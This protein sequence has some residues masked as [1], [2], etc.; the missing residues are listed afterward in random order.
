[1]SARYGLQLPDFGWIAGSDPATTLAR[2]RDVAH[3]AEEAGF[4][5]LWVMDHFYQLQPLGGPSQ[6]MLEAYT[7]LGALAACTEHVQLGALVT[8]VTYRNP[9][10][11]AKQATT[12]DLLSGG[13][14]ILGIG[15]AWYDVEHT[16]F[17]VDFPPLAERFER[18]EEALRICRA[19]FTE[20][21]AS[22]AGKHYRIEAV[23]NLPAP[24]RR[25]GIPI[26]VG[27]AGEKKTL[28]L[29]ARYADAC[30]VFGGP[31]TVRHKLAVLDRHC[32]DVGRDPK[33]IRRTRLGS[34][35]LCDTAEQAE[36][37]R[38]SLGEGVGEQ[39]IVGTRDEVVRDVRAL[40]AAGL[41]EVIF[42]VPGARDVSRFTEAG[43]VLAEAC[44]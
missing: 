9:S 24:V 16:A 5:S 29:V 13:R 21:A 32:A 17:G 12:L 35:F 18:L 19:M 8:G 22:F 15:A 4:S 25:G 14:A 30:N 42:N 39:F 6:P 38:K 34:L 33:S 31:D 26:L 11:L 44:A 36:R 27:G 1:V 2:L 3:A 20:A 10:I 28:K 41:D 43:K 37:L 23:K 7:T 40:V